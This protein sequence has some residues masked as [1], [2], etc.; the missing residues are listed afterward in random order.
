MELECIIST[1][2]LDKAVE[3]VFLCQGSETVEP[4]TESDGSPSIKVLDHYRLVVPAI[5]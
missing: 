4:S 2:R 5:A 1:I 3:S